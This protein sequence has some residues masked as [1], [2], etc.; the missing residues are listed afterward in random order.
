MKCCIVLQNRLH[1]PSSQPVQ[2]KPWIVGR[3][4]TEPDNQHT[5]P[6]KEEPKQTVLCSIH[7]VTQDTSSTWTGTVVL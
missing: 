5:A 3:K 6:L 7:Y 2:I 4:Q 1:K